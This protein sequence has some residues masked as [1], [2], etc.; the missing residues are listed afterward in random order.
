[1]TSRPSGG[2]QPGLHPLCW[3]AGAGGTGVGFTSRRAGAGAST[4]P[5]ASLNLGGAV[6]DDA[7][8]VTRNRALV[9]EA[10]GVAPDRLLFAEQVHGTDVVVADGPWAGAAP[11]ADAVVTRTPGLALGVLVADCVPVVL[12]D[13]AEGVVGVAHAGRRG[14][15]A[16]VVPAVLA[17]LRDLGARRVEAHVGPSVCA[18]CYEVPP[19]MRDE[20]AA[21]VPVSASVTRTGTASLDLAAGVAAQL[22]DG[23]ATVEVHPG[24]T[25]ER[26]DLY[27]YRRD[28]VTG[29]F[30]GLAWLD[31][32]TATAAGPRA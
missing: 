2:P 3:A 5:Y 4:G 25:A 19:A 27:S 14:L 21:V 32:Q 30:A 7:T 20:V 15:A 11:R 26:D 13:P 28:G 16:G 31:G 10:V 9:A 17:A 12:S 1:M 24:C 23:G 8:A 6:G 22:V 29:R 18:R